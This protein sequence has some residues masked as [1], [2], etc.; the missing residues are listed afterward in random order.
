MSLKNLIL[1]P[2]TAVVVAMTLGACNNNDH[3]DHDHSSHGD[4]GSTA[5]NDANDSYP[6]KTCVVSGEELGS[7]G[8]PVVINHNGTTVK[9]CCKSCVDDFMAEPDKFLAKLTVKP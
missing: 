9:F 5:V 6:L 7:M 1:T 8:E 2:L 4:G 3:T